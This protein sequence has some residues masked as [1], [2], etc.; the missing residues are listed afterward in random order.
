MKSLICFLI[1]FLIS[2]TSLL[3]QA[4]LEPARLPE[5]TVFY[6]LWRGAPAPAIRSANSLYSL[7]DDPDFA[8]AR[9]A[10][11]DNFLSQ[12][13][14]K[15]DANAK[16]SREEFAEYAT[17]LENPFVLGYLSDPAKRN[18]NAPHHRAPAEHREWN[19]FFFVYDRSSKESLLAKAVLRMRAAEKEPPTI[20]TVNIAGIPALKIERKTGITYWMDNGK[21]VLSSGETSVLEEILARLKNNAAPA[22]SLADSSA[23]KEAGSLL[24]SGVLEYFVRISGLRD[25]APESA[26]AAGFRAGPILDALK[27]DSIH[28]F[29]G[30]IVLD[31]SKT[32]LQ[33][34]LLG[35]A[36]QG[37]LF[38]LW[39][40]GQ[41]TPA[42]LSYISPNAISY[43]ETQ[44]NL[45]GIYALAKRTADTLMP[46]GQQNNADLVESMA[47]AR[48]GMSISDVLSAFSGEFA[49]AQTNSALDAGKQ[50]YLF[51]IHNK[52]TSLKLLRHVFSDRISSERSEGNVT[53][54]KISFGGAQNNTGLAQW[55]YYHFAV[56]PDM[57][58]VTNKLDTLREALA[59]HAASPAAGLA[60]SFF[61][62]RS[63]YPP[64]V[65]GLS[66][67]DL[68]KFDWQAIQNPQLRAAA[69]KSAVNKSPE[70]KLTFAPATKTWLDSLDP[71]VFPKHL[72]FSSTTSWKDASGIH[73]DG[74]ID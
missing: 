67:T 4:P 18:A 29:S 53:F 20:S 16:I 51:G 1:L 73:F 42:S 47:R 36:S 61:A 12:S 50:T 8:P 44:I 31:G 11:F 39:D 62:N 6:V 41:A 5:S 74:W 69:N 72:H 59:Q 70:S 64:T 26:G 49:Y 55:N 3:A 34:A 35:D 54:L 27:L 40:A 63:K 15:S 45:Q 43:N 2:A 30:H 60:A 19:G 25:L 23:Y 56:T 57:I 14:K 17:L 71:K 9:S 46:K 37:T 32:R 13:E 22:P 10:M 52:E 65:S 48:L 21:Y 68:Q 28:S 58:L 38:D 7:W 24:G 66:F 33:G